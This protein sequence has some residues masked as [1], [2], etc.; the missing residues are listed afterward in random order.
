MVREGAEQEARMWCGRVSTLFLGVAVLAAS[1][2]AQE[3]ED[4]R[5]PGGSAMQMAKP[6]P[7]MEK[8]KWVIGK[9]SVTETHEKSDSGPAG[10]GKGT[11]V[12][13]LGPG[14][15]SQII[16]YNSKGPTGKF[17]GQGIIAWDPEARI[18]RSAWTDSKTPGIITMD[19]REEGKD[20]VCSGEGTRLGK[21]IA[22]R[23]RSIAP[24]PAGWSEVTEISTDGGPFIKM[25]TFE[26]KRAK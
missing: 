6:A 15:Y 1:V 9:W 8:R 7:E 22:M 17:S 23:S 4:T 3:R 10:I 13:A 11:S 21:K 16:T 26:F 14:G 5:S 24:N 20:W 25:R 19:C 18:Y 2:H 12:V